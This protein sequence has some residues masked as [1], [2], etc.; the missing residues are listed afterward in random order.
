MSDTLNH[1]QAGLAGRYT[2]ECE[3]GH[4]GMA[5]VDLARGAGAGILP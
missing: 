4:G 3:I 1:L 5:V 2:M